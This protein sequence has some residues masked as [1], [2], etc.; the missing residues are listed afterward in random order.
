MEDAKIAAGEELAAKEELTREQRQEQEK[1]RKRK[2]KEQKKL[3]K[4]KKKQ[5]KK[6]R[7]E[8]FGASSDT[9]KEEEIRINAMK[10]AILKEQMRSKARLARKFNRNP[11][12]D[13]SQGRC[14]F[15]KFD[16][17]SG[18]KSIQ[19][20]DMIFIANLP[21]WVFAVW[22]RVDEDRW[23]IYGKM[24]LVSFFL[25]WAAIILSIVISSMI[26][27]SEQEETDVMLYINTLIILFLLCGVIIVDYHFTRVVL[28]QAAIRKKIIDRNL[29]AKQKKE[30][31]EERYRQHNKHRLQDIKSA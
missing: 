5:E 11:K 13:V 7:E 8:K 15:K 23:P 22:A 3:R 10:T 6:K 30:R 19:V 17:D 25:F 26:R 9:S 1:E 27:A 4:K 29:K 21:R 12:F 16:N 31:A 14:C 20:I 18:S 2:R 24:R 28:Y